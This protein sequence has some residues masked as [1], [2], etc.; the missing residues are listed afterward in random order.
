MLGT[1]N[2]Q[3]VGGMVDN[4]CDVAE[5]QITQASVLVL[6][7]EHK[8][9]VSKGAELLGTPT[10]DF[11]DLMHAHG[12]ALEDDTPEEIQSGVRNLERLLQKH[13]KQKKPVC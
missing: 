5:R 2:E 4:N 13:G 7:G 9:T 3:W 11:Y 8:I 1:Q 6:V 10:Q 12:I